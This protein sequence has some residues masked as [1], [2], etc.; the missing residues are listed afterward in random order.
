MAVDTVVGMVTVVFWTWAF[1]V[2]VDSTV[3]VGMLR[4]EHA[5]DRADVANAA[6]AAGAFTVTARF[7]TVSRFA[8]CAPP[9]EIT[10]TV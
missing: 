9:A 7:S 6:S 10:L 5:E 4:H 1:A 8:M 2:K 3:G